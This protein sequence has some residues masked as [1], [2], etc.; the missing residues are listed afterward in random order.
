MATLAV[1]GNLGPSKKNL[2]G[3]V[4]YRFYDPDGTANGAAVTSGVAELPSANT[5]GIYV[6]NAT[7]P[8]TFT[9]GYVVWNSSDS[10]PAYAIEWITPAHLMTVTTIA[11]QVDT[12]LSTSHGSGAWNSASFAVTGSISYTYTVYDVD[13]VTRLPG[14]AVYVSTD[15]AGVNV[16]ATKITD[17]L[18]NVN[19][20]LS[21]G[22]YY[23]WRF[24]P[25]RDFT[26]PDTEIVSS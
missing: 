2:A 4:S 8:A 26:D 9:S 25:S 12:T 1:T 17:A 22:T 15:S 10:S 24:H 18:G 23:F 5:S 16:S 3:T 19:F 20:A 6:A 11:T 7:V 21:A 13:G 14:V